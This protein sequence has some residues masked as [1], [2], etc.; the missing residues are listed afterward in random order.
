LA[1]V[2]TWARLSFDEGV[3]WLWPRKIKVRDAKTCKLI[4]VDADSIKTGPI[5]NKSLSD[6]LLQ[7]VRAIHSTI[8]DVYDVTLE[9]FEIGFMRDAHPEQEVAVWQRIADAY[10]KVLAA[11]PTFDRK[12]VLR[13][14]LAYSM[15]ALTPAE[16]VDP[17]VKKIVEIGEGE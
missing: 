12:M 11:E 10:R 9:Q 15:G 2:V 5:R 13:T 6:D 17:A 3:I 14:L 1:S 16:L 8:R 4:E 7:Q